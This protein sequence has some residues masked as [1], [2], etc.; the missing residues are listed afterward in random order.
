MF[1]RLFPC[2][3]LLLCFGKSRCII[4]YLIFSS[5]YFLSCFC[6][7]FCNHYRY[8]CYHKAFLLFCAQTQWNGYR[9]FFLL[10]YTSMRVFPDNKTI[11]Y[12]ENI[13]WHIYKPKTRSIENVCQF[14]LNTFGD[15][16]PAA[17]DWVFA[18]DFNHISKVLK[19]FLHIVYPMIH[20]KNVCWAMSPLLIFCL[21]HSHTLHAVLLL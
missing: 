10:S 4:L 16:K 11:S 17:V 18:I 9:Q 13:C 8:C 19:Q 21:I 20:C 5:F 7:V 6:L 14:L 15:L 2:L 3:Y 12:P 1:V